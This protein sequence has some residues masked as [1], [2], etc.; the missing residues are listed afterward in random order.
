M[1]GLRRVD[2]P[3]DLQ[4]D[5]RRQQLEQPTASAEQHWDLVDLQLIQHTGL[6]RAFSSSMNF[7]KAG[8]SMPV[9]NMPSSRMRCWLSGFAIAMLT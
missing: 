4:L 1:R 3:N 9:T 2:H 6:Q 5:A 7:R 8:A